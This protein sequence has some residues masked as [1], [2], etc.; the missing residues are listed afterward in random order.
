MDTAG[1]D[2]H[3]HLG[4]IVRIRVENFMTYDALEVKPGP[5]LNMILGPNGTG[6]STIVCCIIVGLAGEVSLTGRGGSPADFV[7]KNTNSALTEIELFNDHGKNY[8]I[9]RKI[10]IT[11]RSATKIDHKS[12]W[13]INNVHKL[14]ADVT[15]L[16]KKLNIKV[17]N[18]CQFLPQD[19]VTQFVKM[20]TCELLLNTLKAAG[21]N[22][23]VEDH[24]KLVHLT[25]N[26]DLKRSQLKE[27]ERS[28]KENEVN[29][30]R[31]ESEVHQLRERE[32]LVKLKNI[33]SQKIH[34]V[35]YIQAKEQVKQAKSDLDRLKEELETN[36]SLI[37][38]YK[39]DADFHRDQ[40]S[41][42][43][44]SID[45]S[46]NELSK[47]QKLITEAQSKIDECKLKCQEEFGKFKSR[48]EQ[49]NERLAT[50]RL[51]HQEIKSFKDRY[52]EMEDVDYRDQL[53][54]LDRKLAIIKKER[55]DI[56]EKKS[57]IS[58]S[59][60]NLVKEIGNCKNDSEI[61]LETKSKKYAILKSKFPDAWKAQEWL[62]LN[63][64]DPRFETKIFPPLMCEINVR[65]PKFNSVVENSIPR[66]ELPAF[67]CQ[68]VNDVRTFSR[69]VR[70]E[71]KLR[72]NVMLVPDKTM[73]DFMME[74]G[75]LTHNTRLGVSQ[76]LMDLIDAPEPILR[77]LCASNNFHRIPVVEDC[78]ET[79]LAMLMQTLPKFYANNELFTSQK[80]RYDSKTISSRDFV[81]P[82]QVLIYS[83]DRQRLEEHKTKLEKLR[84]DQEIQIEVQ[85]KLF[86][87]DDKLRD[88]WQNTVEEHK[89]LK[90]KSGEKNRLMAQ[91]TA[92]E[93]SLQD[94]ENDKIDLES[95]R[96]KLHQS[97]EKI[98]MNIYAKYENLV[99]IHKDLVK[100]RHMQMHNLL[101]L[102]CAERN[103]KIA[104]QKYTNSKRDIA[105]LEEVIKKASATVTTHKNA[106]EA[107]KTI[108][109]EKVPCLKKNPEKLDRR[110][111]ENFAKIVEDDVDELVA[112]KED[113]SVRI[114][115]IYR[116]ASNTVLSEFNRQNEEL[117]DKK[118]RIEDLTNSIK[119]I[120]KDRS[121]TKEGWLPKL[122]KVID[123]IDK[124]Y[125]N[126][127]RN[128]RYDGQV[129]L[130]M[131]VHDL[132]NFAS[133]GIMILVRYRD[134]E[135][136]IPL[137]STRQSGG[138]R[139]VATMIY[140]LA[141]Q[142]HTT[143]PF[144]C[145]DEINQGMDKDNERKVFELLVQT[146]DSS[147]AQYF[148][149]SPKL[150]PNLPYS[151]KM[152]IHIIFN[153]PK[154]QMAWSDI[155]N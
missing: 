40:E 142:T 61:Q 105:R 25:K 93:R 134:N 125:R 18:L 90:T 20:N 9:T 149:V 64:S 83:I 14:K 73:D 36:M 10:S 45:G 42:I 65:E 96:G 92:A 5:R 133:Y 136:L 4:S 86:A 31:L 137:S 2:E 41:R 120:D 37:R 104:R 8:I 152:K 62:A 140:M 80:S 32:E 66:N 72:I 148:L 107:L 56:I 117:K 81:R 47:F 110:T 75:Q 113:L 108:A 103:S 27:L 52:N 138:E 89:T 102:K 146:A 129:K 58:A 6:K 144:R 1:D 70:D 71:L 116:D 139:S 17:D 57:I 97:I 155:L 43:R 151:D 53:R 77:H 19:S 21:D 147:S 114:S 68:S 11:G 101:L 99:S 63:N 78:P 50:L 67:I 59:L 13:M 153:G 44:Q 7:K 124:N 48:Q 128:L 145:V 3:N 79:K 39:D 118:A 119:V 49:E 24:Q 150:L 23:L 34:Y 12:E 76:Y 143:A 100:F 154:M 130:D 111:K 28:C 95:E 51:K 69:I 74:R 141:L 60:S 22:E 46:S 55:Q 29:A 84:N 121:T 26:I 16:T 35:R 38:P 98:N 109:E 122:N 106:L 54:E 91:I 85:R 88:D 115:R 15:A 135:Q 126:F 123:V 131:D 132:D 127:M 82:A 94:L 87:Q 112:K 30:A 33:C